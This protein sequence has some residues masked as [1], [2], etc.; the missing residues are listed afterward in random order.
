MLS[1]TTLGKFFEQPMPI[2][3][4]LE[5]RLFKTSVTSAGSTLAW[6]QLEVAADGHNCI[7]LW[8][9]GRLPKRIR[10]LSSMIVM[11]KRTL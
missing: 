8:K 5:W 2:S 9:C 10:N 7:P 4:N 3:T 1:L 6:N 11:K